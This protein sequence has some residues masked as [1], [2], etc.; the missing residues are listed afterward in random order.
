MLSANLEK[1]LNIAANL[2][3][4]SR[5]EFV[6]LEHILLAFLGDAETNE[7]LLACGANI[8]DL[9]KN[10]EQFIDRYSPRVNFS[11]TQIAI[12]DDVDDHTPSV[13]TYKPE[14]TLACHRL[15][16]RFEVLSHLQWRFYRRPVRQ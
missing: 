16:Q 1:F 13:E 2:A 5:H 9:R 6:S 11:N 3:K 7:I 14:F 8:S 15:L 10:L 12:G 4:N